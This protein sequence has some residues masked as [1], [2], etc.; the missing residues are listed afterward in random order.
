MH[1]VPYFSIKKHL[2]L[3]HEIITLPNTLASNVVFLNESL[4]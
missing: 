1:A 3:N 4:E 2:C